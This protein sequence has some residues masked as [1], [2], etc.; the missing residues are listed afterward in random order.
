MQLHA[1]ENGVKQVPRASRRKAD[2]P[3]TAGIPGYNWYLMDYTSP[4]PSIGT[5]RQSYP[6]PKRNRVG[7]GAWP[8]VVPDLV[9]PG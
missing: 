1:R 6:D 5:V 7:P 9:F 3:G 4:F 8:F 2:Q